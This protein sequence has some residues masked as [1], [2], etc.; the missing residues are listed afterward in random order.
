MKVFI[1]GAGAAARRVSAVLHAD[2][3]LLGYIDN[4]KEKQGQEY[5]GK[6]VFSPEILKSK[7]YDYII[8]SPYQYDG[9][10]RQLEEMGINAD[11]I[12]QFFNYTRLMPFA[13]FYNENYINE[14]LYQDIFDNYVEA[15]LYS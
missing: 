14:E 1:W 9:I 5:L 13:F 3:D 11:K 12:I 2:T 15:R 4:A 8:I 7:D 10:S 6:T